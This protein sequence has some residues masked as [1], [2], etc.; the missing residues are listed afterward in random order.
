[1]QSKQF[2]KKSKEYKGQTFDS[3]NH[4]VHMFSDGTIIQAVYNM[5]EQSQY[6]AQEEIQSILDDPDK[7]LFTPYIQFI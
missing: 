1:M 3:A 5:G 4:L 6:V 2:N 7:Y